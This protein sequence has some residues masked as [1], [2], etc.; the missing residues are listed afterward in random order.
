MMEK[1][2]FANVPTSQDQYGWRD[3]FID[4]NPDF[5]LH[6]NPIQEQETVQLFM[7][8]HTRKVKG[9]QDM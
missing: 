4:K 9:L 5:K 2:K 3:P 7:I 8:I 6:Y 1:G